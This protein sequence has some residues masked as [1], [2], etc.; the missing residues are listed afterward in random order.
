VQSNTFHTT[1]TWGGELRYQLQ[2]ARFGTLTECGIGW[3]AFVVSYRRED[4]CIAKSRVVSSTHEG[5]RQWLYQRDVF[6]RMSKKKTY[7]ELHMQFES[8]HKPPLHKYVVAFLHAVSVVCVSKRPMMGRAR[9][10]S[11]ECQR[12]LYPR[13]STPS[14]C[15]LPHRIPIS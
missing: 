8:H 10:S 9:V 11:G 1:L 12:Q 15:V 6:H 14:L 4:V 2:D 5:S 7:I 13:S 3:Q